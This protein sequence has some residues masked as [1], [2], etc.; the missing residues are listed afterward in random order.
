MNQNKKSTQFRLYIIITISLT[1]ITVIFLNPIIWEWLRINGSFFLFYLSLNIFIFHGISQLLKKK[2]FLN[3]S[4]IAYFTLSAVFFYYKLIPN[5]IDITLKIWEYPIQD[6]FSYM[7]LYQIIF[8]TGTIYL[9]IGFRQIW[10]NS[11]SDPENSINQS[12]NIPL[13]IILNLL[14]NFSYSISAGILKKMFY[15]SSL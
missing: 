15:S 12:F 7:I 1:I 5:L 14:M 4:M 8:L 2:I 6:V 10:K 11:F 9:Y 3:V 13:F